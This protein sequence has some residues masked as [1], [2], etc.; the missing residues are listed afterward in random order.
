MGDVKQAIYR[1]R[2][3]DWR[4]LN[5]EVNYTLS[6]YTAEKPFKLDTN[7]RSCEDVIGFNNKLFG[8]C[9]KLL[10]NLLGGQYAEA[11]K[12]AYSDVEQKC[13]PK[14]KGGYVRVTNVTP[15]EEESATEAMCR[16]VTSVIDELRSKGVPDNKIAI[17]VRKNSQITSMVEYMSKKRPDI[18]S[19]SLC[20]RGIHCHQHADNGIALDC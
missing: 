1:W 20:A 3:S 10:E 18:L 16:E 8:Q 6:D 17:I 9:N 13:D 11:L 2:G 12:Q 5:E 4:I 14:N 15:D 19:R 7:R